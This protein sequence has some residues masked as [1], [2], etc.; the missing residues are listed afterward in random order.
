MDWIYKQTNNAKEA[1]RATKEY[2]SNWIKDICEWMYKK[3]IQLKDICRTVCEEFKWN[4]KEIVRWFKAFAK[5]CAIKWNAL[6]AVASEWLTI[7]V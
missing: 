1:I 5:D 7:D 6:V 3:W 4:V 2:I